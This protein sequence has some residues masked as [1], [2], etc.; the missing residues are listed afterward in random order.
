M[1][2]RSKSKKR[3]ELTSKSAKMVIYM[4]HQHHAHLGE[5]D[6]QRPM[7]VFADQSKLSQLEDMEAMGVISRTNLVEEKS[8]CRYDP[9]LHINLEGS[10]VI[11]EIKSLAEIQ[12]E[13]KTICTCDGQDQEV[14][15]MGSQ[16]PV[17]RLNLMAYSFRIGESIVRKIIYKISKAI[18]KQLQPTEMLQPYEQ[19]WKE[20][21]QKFWQRWD[22]PNTIGAIDGKHVIIQAPANTGSLYFSYKKSFSVVLLALISAN[23]KFIVTDVGSYGKNSDGAIFS[24]SALGQLLRGNKLP[25]PSDKALPVTDIILPHVIVGDEA[26]PL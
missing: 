4:Q 26:F 13:L 25:T 5:H 22:F 21:E 11:S 23:C 1:D 9:N 18:W 15:E 2:Q 17:I 12:E 10:R 19:I 14:E 24:S 7:P 6:E 8:E 16:P 3:S 20:T